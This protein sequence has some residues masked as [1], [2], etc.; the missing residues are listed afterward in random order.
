MKNKTRI[1]MIRKERKEEEEE[2]GEGI[3]FR[4]CGAMNT[5]HRR[6]IPSTALAARHVP[7]CIV[8]EPFMP[9]RWSEPCSKGE[10]LRA[11]YLIHARPRQCHFSSTFQQL[12]GKWHGGE[13]R[14]PAPHERLKKPKSVAKKIT[15][16]R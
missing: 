11:T 10:M 7:P 2:E 13:C 1:A 9:W 15:E 6:V 14:D 5:P 4:L 8:P 12:N 3:A 16:V